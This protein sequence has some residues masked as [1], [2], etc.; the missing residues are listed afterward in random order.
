M[1]TIKKNIVVRG[2]S[3]GLILAGNHNTQTHV[4]SFMKRVKKLGFT[5]T[6]RK[7]GN[8]YVVYMEGAKGTPYTGK[9]GSN[10]IRRK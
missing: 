8:Y 6:K 10:K 1:A 4:D 7:V 2:K 5:V 3:Y 9:K